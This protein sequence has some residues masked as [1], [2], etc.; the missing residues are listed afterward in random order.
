[1]SSHS[2]IKHLLYKKYFLTVLAA[3]LYYS[4]IVIFD[5]PKAICVTELYFGTC[6]VLYFE[7]RYGVSEKPTTVTCTHNESSGFH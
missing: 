1:M 2:L 4:S 5:V 6:D 7:I 3:Y